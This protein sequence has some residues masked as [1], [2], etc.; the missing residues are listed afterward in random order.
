MI[1]LTKILKKISKYYFFIFKM[2]NGILSKPY[3][4]MK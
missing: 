1:N 4:M 3:K 2:L